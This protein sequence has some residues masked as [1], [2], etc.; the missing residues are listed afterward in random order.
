[1]D[2]YSASYRLNRRE[3]RHLNPLLSSGIDLP[4]SPKRHISNIGSPTSAHPRDRPLDTAE[5]AHNRSTKRYQVIARMGR[6][7]P[8]TR[9]D[10]SPETSVCSH[11]L[12]EWNASGN[13]EHGMR[14]GTTPCASQ[15]GNDSTRARWQ[16]AAWAGCGRAL[17]TGESGFIFIWLSRSERSDRDFVVGFP[18]LRTA[19][20]NSPRR[21]DPGYP[22][23]CPFLGSRIRSLVASLARL[24]FR[25]QIRRPCI[26]FSAG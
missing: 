24:G 25:R 22:L 17:P 3:A 20:Q 6:F 5:H 21:H 11:P 14:A 10:A 4:Y 12:H 26:S 18:V 13:A 23:R 19:R 2:Y 1:L 15:G 7:C 9:N 8:A 16:S